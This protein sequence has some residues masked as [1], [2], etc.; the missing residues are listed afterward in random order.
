MT[1]DEE[2]MVSGGRTCHER[3]H[4]IGA[5]EER[6]VTRTAALDVVGETGIFRNKKNGRDIERTAIAGEGNSVIGERVVSGNGGR[7]V[8]NTAVSEKGE[9]KVNIRGKRW[10]K[11]FWGEWGC[12]ARKNQNSR[13]AITLKR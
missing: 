7:S 10:L 3:R 11:N 13:E 4:R 5:I 12:L 9:E 8:G 6:K 1:A 2:R